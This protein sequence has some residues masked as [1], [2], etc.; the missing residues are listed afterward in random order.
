M[1]PG[2]PLVIFVAV[3]RVLIADN[4]PASR[5]LVAASLAQAGVDVLTANNGDQ[6][7]A[8]LQERHPDLAALDVNMPGLTGLELT[9]TIR[10]DETLH[11]MPVILISALDDEADIAAAKSAGADRYV[12]KP[13]SPGALRAVVKELLGPD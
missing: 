4:D 1:R 10:A 13:F 12:T 2:A 5:Q 7:L 3:K 11:N 8:L 9:R 6:A